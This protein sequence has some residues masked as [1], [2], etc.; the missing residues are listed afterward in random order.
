MTHIHRAKIYNISRKTEDDYF[1]FLTRDLTWVERNTP[2]QKTP[3]VPT[4]AWGDPWLEYDP[5]FMQ[6][7]AKFIKSYPDNFVNSHGTMWYEIS[8]AHE[9]FLEWLRSGQLEKAHEHLN[10]MHQ[11]PLLIGISQGDVETH[12][13]K[14]YPEVSFVR[15][16]RHYDV[17][18]GVMEYLGIIGPQNHEQGAS[19]VAVSADTLLENSPKFIV[20]PKWQGGLYGIQTSRGLFSDRDLMALYIALKIKSKYPLE[21]RIMEIGGGAGQVAYW[22]YQLGYRNIFMVDLPGVAACQAYQLAANIGAE[23]VSF[24][25]E[26]LQTAVKFLLPSQLKH[27]VDRFNLVVNSD[28]MPEM[29]KESLNGYLEFIANNSDSFYS[30]NQE[31]R[32]TSL[33]MNAQHVVHRVIKK[34]FAERFTRIDRSKFWL[35][36]GY[37]EEWYFTNKTG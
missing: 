4:G 3:F 17:L 30:I 24:S 1:V 20:A 28:S 13:L 23:N 25:H 21:S 36:D 22:L 35:R 19:F 6:R 15:L 16:L 27:R 9:F 8:N 14:N 18:L 37:T 2:D 5:V 26:N 33:D 10:L 29:D 34:E 7:L 31:A 32:S 12:Y 11:S